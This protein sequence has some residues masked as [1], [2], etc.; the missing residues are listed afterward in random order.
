MQNKFNQIPDSYDTEL[1][2]SWPRYRILPV[3]S[4][5]AD[6]LD[7]VKIAELDFAERLMFTCLQGIVNRE[8]P[9]IF[10]VPERAGEGNTAWP[11]LLGLN[12][13]TFDGD[14]K[15]DLL[16]KYISSVNGVILY[17]CDKS[18]H[19]ANLA[20]TLAGI[21]DSLPVDAA[22]YEKLKNN[23]ISLSVTED[24]TEF[25]F[26]DAIGIYTYMYEN[27]WKYCTHRLIVSASPTNPYYVRDMAVC[28]RAAVVWTENRKEEEKNVYK[29][30]LADMKAGEAAATGW[31]TEERS[32]IGAAAEFGLSTIPS[33]FY[34][35]STVYAGTPHEIK[36]PKIPPMPALENKVYA[37]IYLSD[38]DNVQYNQH[39]ML[40]LW[41]NPDRGSIPINWT[42]SPVL[43]DF[44]PGL[45]NYYY[46]TATEGDC[47]VSGPSGAGYSL[48]VDRHNKK[49]NLTDKSLAEKYV[50]LTDRYLEKSGIHSIT[51]WDEATDM[52]ADVYSEKCRSLYGAT[53]V[54]W[55]MLPNPLP[56][57]DRENIAF[58]PNDPGYTNN[59]E[60]IYETFAKKIAKWDKKS[61]LFLSAQGVSW[62]MTPAN[63]KSLVEQLN[64]LVPGAIEIVRA[65]H[66]FAL[67]NKATNRAYNLCLEGGCSVSESCCGTVV[68][69]G[70]A[71]E[72]SR[73][74][75]RG[76][77]K[78]E[79]STSKDGEN[80][81]TLY[82]SETD[83]AGVDID[84][85]RTE[86]QF[87]K[88]SAGITSP[89]IFGRYAE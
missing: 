43:T 74:R 87:V 72:I 36:I 62:N 58:I 18:K 30:F 40:N 42:V 24:I 78:I 65:D 25:E 35:N 16:R 6:V 59:I 17:S 14:E 49:V 31:Y 2:M 53:L 13:K 20:T 67:Y 1:G 51:I 82:E 29:L 27:L 89:E 66:F 73:I 56:V 12:L 70:K 71:A 61:P 19:Y 9:R 64:K 48:I 44:G 11:D 76:S 23:G 7:S 80:Y 3:L 39:A 37:A 81:T 26:T 21:T 84:I 41:R 34:E 8:K 5:P 4:K 63:V 75:V 68:D 10:L 83:C 15:F 22:L 77:G 47:F 88:F 45:M 52:H 57:I 32:G 54:D 79:I 55:R 69:L 86:A 85:P 50:T 38:G 46:E 33:D 28:T 60:P